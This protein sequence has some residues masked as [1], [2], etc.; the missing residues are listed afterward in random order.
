MEGG[1]G[2][3]RGWGGEI[4]RE[5]GVWRSEKRLHMKRIGI[6]EFASEAEK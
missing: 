4:S 6:E 1:W 3:G 2:V 5:L